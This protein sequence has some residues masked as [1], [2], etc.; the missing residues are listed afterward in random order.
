MKFSTDGSGWLIAGCIICLTATEA[1]GARS[2]ISTLL[3]GLVF[4]AIYIMKQFFDP[5]GIGWFIAGGVLGA[6]LFE[7][8]LTS[9]GVTTLFIAVPC[10]IIFYIQNRKDIEEVVDEVETANM[11]DYYGRNPDEYSEEYEE[12]EEYY[13]GTPDNYPDSYS[14]SHSEGSSETYPEDFSETYPEE[15]SGTYPEEPSGTCPEEP[16]ETYPEE[17]SGTYPEESGG[18]PAAALPDNSNI[19]EDVEFD[20]TMKK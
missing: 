6:F 16:S 20:I 5:S 14:D 15:P 12:Y 9:E 19:G 3:F 8:G 17:P 10:L 7:E 11:N 2:I 1:Y 4:I 13:E 18:A